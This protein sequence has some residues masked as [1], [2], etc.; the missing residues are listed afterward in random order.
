MVC[1]CFTHVC[2]HS[3]FFGLSMKSWKYTTGASLSQHLSQP[4]LVC[5]FLNQWYLKLCFC[6]YSDIKCTQ[7]CLGFLTQH[8]CHFPISPLPLLWLTWF[9]MLI[10]PAPL[11]LGSPTVNLRLLGLEPKPLN[12]L[13][14]A[15]NLKEWILSHYPQP[16]TKIHLMCLLHTDYNIIPR[17]IWFWFITNI[18]SC[19]P[20]SVWKILH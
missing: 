18:I 3:S 4:C 8:K 19:V 13:L 12:W 7:K 16:M 14:K 1:M 2:A 10:H 20:P 6:H 5:S 17:Y 9:P 15:S 11:S